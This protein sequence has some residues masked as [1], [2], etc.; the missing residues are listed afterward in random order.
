MPR[1]PVKVKPM[2]LN[3]T[4]RPRF[5]CR[6]PPRRTT[7]ANGNTT[8]AISRP[9]SR[10]NFSRSRAAI[11]AT[12]FI[13]LIADRQDLE[14]RLLERRGLRPQH[15]QWLVDGA[16]DLVCRASI[17]LDGERALLFEWQVQLSEPVPEPHAVRGVDQ[18]AFAD[19]L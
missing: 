5:S 12:A 7:I 17:E 19:Q 10:R 8:A 4:E 11:A 16:H 9:G 13:S 18:Q 1:K 2:K 15:R 14:V 3:P 6:V